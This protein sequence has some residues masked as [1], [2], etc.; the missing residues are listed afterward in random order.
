MIRFDRIELAN[1]LNKPLNPMYFI[2]NEA[3]KLGSV[4]KFQK[5]TTKFEKSKFVRLIFSN[6]SI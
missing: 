4:E 6:D 1:I 5:M 3:L 2:A